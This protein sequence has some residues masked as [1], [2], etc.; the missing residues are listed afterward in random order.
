[1]R[2]PRF[3]LVGL[4]ALSLTPVTFAAGQGAPEGAAATASKVGAA[5]S[6]LHEEYL[7]HERLGDGTVFVPKDPTLRIVE[8]R[9]VIDAV[10]SGETN[11]L[12]GDLESLGMRRAASFGRVVSGQLPIIAIADLDALE[13][14]Q[15]A[16]L[17]VAETG[18]L[19]PAGEPRPGK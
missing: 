12:R 15:F 10:A 11:D 2:T 3:V 7:A 19:G 5:L 6:A 9:V 1:M 4:L 16:R 17:A 8:D 14:L 13:S 18:E